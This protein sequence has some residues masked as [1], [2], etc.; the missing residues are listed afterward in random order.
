MKRVIWVPLLAALVSC[1]TV[2]FDA[3]SIS[4]IYGWVD[5]CNQVKVSGT[6]FGDDL[7][8]SITMPDASGVDVSAELGGLVHAGDDPSVT[9]ERIKALNVGFY[10][11]G[12][13][14][15]SPVASK[16]YASVVVTSGDQTATLDEAYYYVACPADGYL[17]YAD[18]VSAIAS[19]T[20]ITLGGC[21]L[22]ASRMMV[23]LVDTTGAPA[24]APAS[25]TSSCG[26]ATVS[27]AAPSVPDGD[28][29]IT[30]V[31]TKGNLLW[32]EPC[33]IQDSATYYC[34]DFPITYGGA[35]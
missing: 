26:T 21:S 35:K 11:L 23:Q 25:L 28:Y 31:D 8:V 22:D 17:E 33:G 30:I 6:A 3:V 13:M 14:P 29:Y 19:G 20:P 4:P 7:A 32:G 15:A 27:F 2:G 9:D 34:T 16:G 12:T 24:G 1:N 5:G 10:V 18:P